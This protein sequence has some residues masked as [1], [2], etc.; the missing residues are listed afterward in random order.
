MPLVHILCRLRPSTS[1]HIVVADT[2]KNTIISSE[3]GEEYHFK[4]VFGPEDAVEQEIYQNNLKGVLEKHS[5]VTV[6]FYGQTGAG[7]T[8]TFCGGDQANGGLLSLFL[9]DAFVGGTSFTINATDIYNAKTHQL[10]LGQVV[11]SAEEAHVVVARLMKQRKTAS[12]LANVCSSRSHLICS[13]T[14][15]NKVV[16]FIDLAGSER[17]EVTGTDPTRR[18]EAININKSL[19]SLRDVIE[20]LSQGKHHIPFRNSP[21]TMALKE[22][23]MMKPQT[24]DPHSQGAFVLV[25][26]C[27]PSERATIDTLRF[28]RTATKMSRGINVRNRARLIISKMKPTEP[29][30]SPL[31][32]IVELENALKTCQAELQEEKS[33]KRKNQCGICGERGHNKRRCTRGLPSE[34][35]VEA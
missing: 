4:A 12:T 27:S 33:K 15:P 29:T 9:Q 26:C 32:R 25:L 6:A 10:L 1:P 31:E 28:G 22:Y 24:S 19:T 30:P 34:E 3:R 2:E 5:T 16:T 13:F 18:Q 14:N 7:K 35:G 23:L 8:T 11:S 21:L 17:L 20:S